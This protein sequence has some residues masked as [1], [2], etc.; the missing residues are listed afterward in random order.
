MKILLILLI[1][2]SCAENYYCVNG[3]I[4]REWDNH[5]LIELGISE[6]FM[7]VKR[8]KAIKK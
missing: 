1:V 5:E 2:S 4:Y 7:C 8:P 3:R 6:Y